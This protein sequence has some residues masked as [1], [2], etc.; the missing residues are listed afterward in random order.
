[1][2]NKELKNH[3]VTLAAGGALFLVLMPILLYKNYHQK[4]KLIKQL[5]EQNRDILQEN[6]YLE[7]LILVRNRIFSIISHDLRG[8]VNSIKGI[9]DFMIE[10]EMS[11]EEKSFYI[12]K[13]SQSLHATSHLADSLLYWAKSQMNG[14]QVNPLL[15][16]IQDIIQQN[17]SLILTRATEK[18]IK[19]VTKRRKEP[20]LVFADSTMIDTVIRNIVENAVKF[21]NAGN[22]II[23]TTQQ[24]E[25]KVIIS[26]QDDGQGIP[27][28]AQSKIFNKDTTYT[29]YG[30][31]NEKGSGLGLLLCK[32]L[33]EKNNGT[34]WF[35]S[36]PDQGT[37]FSFTIPLNDER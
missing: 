36:V 17:V 34:I 37:T 10:E 11:E 35:E 27:L 26:I 33:V 12:E 29:S 18:Q 8:P 1:M 28:E 22:S 16:D 5:E 32:E 21:L 19:I 2:K 24:E 3:E 6:E 14:A 20:Q 31:A 25:N 30:T 7:E 13:I 9:V 23:I 4:K 15:F